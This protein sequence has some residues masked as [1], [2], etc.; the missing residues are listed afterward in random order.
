[1]TTT[2]RLLSALL[3]AA[4]FACGGRTSLG[5]GTLG[6]DGGASSVTLMIPLGSYPG[7][8]AETVSVAP[9]FE[10][11]AG[12]VG[13]VTL[14]Q[15]NDTVVAT[16]AF[17]PF[18]SGKLAFTPTSTSTAAFAAGRSF[19]VEALDF[20]GSNTT[21]TE[22]T[23]S[24]VLVGDTLFISTHGQSASADVSGHVHC[25]VPASLQPTSVATNA[26]PLAAL[27]PG[28]FG[29]C[30][31]S[32]GAT[33]VG[34]AGGGSGSVTVTASAGALSATWNDD[35]TPVCKHLDFNDATLVTGQTCS[36][37]RPCGPPPSL[38]PS[39]APSVA[40][41]TSTAGAMTANGQSLFIDL[42]GETTT[43]ACG[44]HYL[45]IVCAPAGH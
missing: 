35:V 3:A 13:T 29:P 6:T 28:I 45:S 43:E 11:V 5:S 18:A 9:R 41:L 10:G 37:Q 30:T 32:V 12:G 42:V 17:A 44:R 1:M 27:T 38:G 15:E 8:T 19:Q 4:C 25:P 22:T 33:N 39:T 20:K 16:L 24:L 40:L 23:G 2:S 21:V 34:L 26:P 36:V 7:C 31:S 14:V